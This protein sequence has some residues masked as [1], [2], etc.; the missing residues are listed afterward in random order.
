MSFK[1]RSG[2]RALN[3]I[4][5]KL[6]STIKKYNEISIENDL[7]LPN[8]EQDA[9]NKNTTFGESKV[10]GNFNNNLA[11]SNSEEFGSLGGAYYTNDKFSNTQQPMI[12][13]NFGNTNTVIV[14]KPPDMDKKHKHNCC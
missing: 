2:N 11:T 3:E 4:S 5:E 13:T 9:F 14:P 8:K 7:F 10:S 1:K 6:K 12:P